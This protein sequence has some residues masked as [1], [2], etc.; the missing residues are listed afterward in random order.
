MDTIFPAVIS[1]KNKFG[2][3][4]ATFAAPYIF[5]HETENEMKIDWKV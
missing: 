3:H 2:K 4:F 5:D 1:Y